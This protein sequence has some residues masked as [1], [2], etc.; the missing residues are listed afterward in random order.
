MLEDALR[1]VRNGFFLEQVVIFNLD[2]IFF[3]ENLNSMVD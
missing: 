1:L 3:F 2:Q